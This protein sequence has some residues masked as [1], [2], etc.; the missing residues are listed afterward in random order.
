MG[1]VFGRRSRGDA[2]ENITPKPR[3]R[4]GNGNR[5]SKTKNNINRK[6][7]RHAAWESFWDDLRGPKGGDLISGTAARGG[8][9]WGVLPFGVIHTVH[10]Y[11]TI[12]VSNP[13]P[14]HTAHPGGAG[15]GVPRTARALA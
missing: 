4:W 6:N 3:T 9:L 14:S 15:S 13:K 5:P 12:T 1:V 11:L 10:L 8:V 2:H 7:E